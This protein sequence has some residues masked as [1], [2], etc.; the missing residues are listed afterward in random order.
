MDDGQRLSKGL[1]AEF[2][3]LYYKSFGERISASEAEINLISLMELITIT[4][5][6][7]DEEEYN[8]DKPNNDT[9]IS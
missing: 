9:R 7:L 8:Y 5:K 1:V 6:P 3:E 2:Q 4:Q